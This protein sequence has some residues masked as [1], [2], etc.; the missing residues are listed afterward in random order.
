MSSILLSVRYKVK[1]NDITVSQITGVMIVCS[2]FCLGADHRKHQS[3]VSLAFV[4]G[5][6]RWPVNS[7]RASNAENVSIWWRHHHRSTTTQD[8]VGVMSEWC[9]ALPSYYIL[10]KDSQPLTGRLCW[11]HADTSVV[12][13][14]EMNVGK[15]EYFNQS[16]TLMTSFTFVLQTT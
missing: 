12:D 16:P 8:F 1:R 7:Q 9:L 11:A 15:V 13:W 3:S 10:I 5:I 6:H 14:S 2:T 4:R